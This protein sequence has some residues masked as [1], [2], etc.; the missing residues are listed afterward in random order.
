MILSKYKCLFLL[1]SPNSS[2][3]LLRLCSFINEHNRNKVIDE[4]GDFNK[5]RHLYLDSINVKFLEHTIES[6]L[7]SINH[8]F[9]NAVLM[10][11]IKKIGS[12]NLM[13]E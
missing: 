5:K 10:R 9:E 12:S 3:T 1:K 11:V 6:T 4:L 2:I 13:V 8:D 7:K